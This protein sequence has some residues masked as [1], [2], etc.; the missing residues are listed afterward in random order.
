MSGMT[1]TPLSSKSALRARRYGSGT[2]TFFITRSSDLGSTACSSL[3]GMGFSALLRNSLLKLAGVSELLASVM[4][5]GS[6][7]RASPTPWTTNRF[8][9]SLAALMERVGGWERKTEPKKKQHT[10]SIKNNKNLNQTKKAKTKRKTK[11]EAIIQ[12]C[13]RKVVSAPK[14]KRG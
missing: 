2:G 13:N 7:G 8:V 5:R 3:G 1:G 11:R 9:G 6:I 10:H 12:I 14:K 4:L